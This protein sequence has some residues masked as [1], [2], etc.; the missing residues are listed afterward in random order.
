[1]D[2]TGEDVIN[3]RAPFMKP[4]LGKFVG[5]VAIL[6]IEGSDHEVR[7]DTIDRIVS[8]AARRPLTRRC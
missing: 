5:D 7:I 2:V 3:Y 6:I 1:M 4:L 8:D